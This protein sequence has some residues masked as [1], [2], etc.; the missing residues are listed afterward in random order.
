MVHTTQAHLNKNSPLLGLSLGLGVGADLVEFLV[1][2]AQSAA[3]GQDDLKPLD[4]RAR[5]RLLV[6]SQYA[7]S[8]RSST[9][10]HVR[11][12]GFAGIMSLAD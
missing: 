9:T 3:V 11:K 5:K 8:T 7:G 6:I 4:S 10:I 2:G 12:N 1:D